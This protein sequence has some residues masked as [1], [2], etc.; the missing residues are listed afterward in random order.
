MIDIDM[1]DRYGRSI[2]EIGHQWDIG[3]DIDMGHGSSMWDMVCRY[4]IYHIVMVSLDID[5]RYGLMIWNM[6][7]LIRSSP[8]SIWDILSL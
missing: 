2:R 6:T 8:M 3:R 1:G 7:V 5:M 4:G